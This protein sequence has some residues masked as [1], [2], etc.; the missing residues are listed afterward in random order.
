[1][2]IASA[3]PPSSAAHC[4]L[5]R[6]RWPEQIELAV[7]PLDEKRHLAGDQPAALRDQQAEIVPLDMREQ[8]RLRGSR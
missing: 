6:A 3:S 4:G 7:A 1:V 5:G 2:K 8:H